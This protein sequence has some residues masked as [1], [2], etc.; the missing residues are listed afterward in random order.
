M[1]EF[2]KLIKIVERIKNKKLREQTMELIKNP[3][4]SGGWKYKAADLKKAPA[5]IGSH[6]Y[7][8]GGLLEH[9]TSVAELS[10]KVA[11]YLERKY[12]KGINI[13]FVIAG[14]VLH[15][16]AKLFEMREEDGKWVFNDFLIDH[17]RTGGAELYARG[18]P[19]EVVHIVMAH[20][21]GDTPRTLE[22]KIV[23]MMDN[24][25][26]IYESFGKEVQQLVYLL[27]DSI[28]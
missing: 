10:I 22:A 2:E 21:G 12:K 4:L 24:L 13:D 16:I 14:A 26:T 7:Y 15:D 5:W 9:T 8:D 27:G 17:V 18:F 6:H 25:D 19:E 28:Q 1:D 20:A 23:D 3:K 11:E